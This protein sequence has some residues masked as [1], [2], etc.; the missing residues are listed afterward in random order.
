MG[1]VDQQHG[2]ADRF[3]H[4]HPVRHRFPRGV[5][6]GLHHQP[7]SGPLLLHLHQTVGGIRGKVRADR[8]R[9]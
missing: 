8:S 2:D 3:D 6:G 1:E 4:L 7:L 5:C 9:R